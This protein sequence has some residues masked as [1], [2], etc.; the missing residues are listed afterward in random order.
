MSKLSLK[1]SRNLPTFSVIPVWKMVFLMLL[2]HEHACKIKRREEGKKK[3]IGQP[4]S[5]LIRRMVL[6]R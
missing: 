2:V 1:T 6:V 4:S 3:A 5:Y